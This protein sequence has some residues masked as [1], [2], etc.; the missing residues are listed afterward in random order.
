[1]DRPEKHG[2]FDRVTFGVAALAA[3]T[4]LLEST[5]TRLLA[6]AQFYH[7]AFLVVSLAL[8]GFG[9]SGTLL[10]LVPRLRAIPIERLLAWCGIAFAASVALAYGVVNRLPFDSYSIAWD[11]RQVLYF[12]LYYLALTLPFLCGGLGIG[13]ALVSSGRRGHL[14]YAANL[15]GSAAGVLIALVALELAGVPGAVVA[16]ASAGL[17]GTIVCS[18]PSGRHAGADRRRSTLARPGCA[19]RAGGFNLLRAL[20]IVILAISVLGFAALA[21]LNLDGRGLLGM[22]ISPYKG[23][24]QARR[25]PGSAA[26]FGQWNAISRV[27]VMA[28]AG[29]RNLPGLS[30]VYQGSPPSQDGLSLDADSLQPIPRQTGTPVEQTGLDTAPNPVSASPARGKGTL[31]D[32]AG[33]STVRPEGFD[34]APFLPEALAFE[35]RP[36]SRTLVIEPGG[37]LG[38]LQALAGGAGEVTAV[39]DNPLVRQAVAKS[40]GVRGEREAASQTDAYAHP[41]VKAVIEPVRSYLARARDRSLRYDVIFLPLTDAFRPVTGGAY[42]LA[43]SYGLTVEAFEAVL[44]RLAPDGLLVATRWLQTPPSEDLRLIAIVKDALERS[45]S[46]ESLSVEPSKA[47]VAYRGIQTLTVLVQPSGWTQAELAEVRQFAQSRRYDLVWAP[48]IVPDETNRFNR[49]PSAEHFE[50]TRALLFARPEGGTGEAGFYASYP[51]DVT[52]P[53]DNRP[54]FYHFFRWGQAPQV[55]A[56]LGKTWQ[57]FGGS[58]YFVLFALL[59]LVLALSAVLILLPLAA[60]YRAAGGPRSRTIVGLPGSESS[61]GERRISHLRVFLYFGLLGVA[62]LFIEIPLIQRWILL[63]G[64]PTY[65][66]TV[67]V[68]TLLLFS[69]L[70]SVLSGSSRLPGHAVLGVLVFLALLTALGGPYVVQSALSWP[71]FWRIVAVIASLAPLALLMGLPFPLGLSWLARAAPGLI[72]WAWAVNG[73]ASVVASVLAAILALSYGFTAVLLLGTLAYAGAWMLLPRSD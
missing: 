45:E 73:C 16:S 2:I 46:A 41:R 13:A 36:N 29:T 59:M 35:L 20:A 71:P 1:M 55:L 66:F 33:S 14:V 42:S 48:D 64:H 70:G 60:G 52:P 6:V 31:K 28:N 63:L 37:G 18:A 3:A 5:L 27:D 53:T 51:F 25:Y 65:A 11:R 49:M 24:A 17:L 40:G 9:A 34:A 23:L 50:A 62:F 12:A 21:A 32:S 67:V 38:I 43:E 15:L 7:F 68:L 58:G 44:A 56:T 57:P 19:K 4:L 22:A 10:S 72:P 47:L 8:L 30:Y 69:S 61:G 26:I 54:F 39:L